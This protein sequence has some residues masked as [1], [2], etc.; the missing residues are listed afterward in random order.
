MDLAVIREELSKYIPSWLVPTWPPSG[1]QLVAGG[2][3][4]AAATAL[5]LKVYLDWLIDDVL[6][7]SR[8]YSFNKHVGGLDNLYDPANQLEKQAIQIPDKTF[9]L[10]EDRKY[11]F[12]ETNSRANQVANAIQK[13]EITREQ[14]VAVL[15]RN[16]PE[17]LF[18]A[19]GCFKMVIPISFLNT[20]LRT[21]ALLHCIR[22]ASTMNLIVDNEPDLLEAVSEIS[23][24]LAEAGVRVFVYGD[25]AEHENLKKTIERCDTRQFFCPARLELTSK[26]VAFYIFTSGT[27]GLPKAAKISYYK[28]VRGSGFFHVFGVKSSDVVYSPLPLYHSAAMI[29]F[30][31]SALLTGCTFSFARK[32]SVRHFWEDC[33]KHGATV[34]QY[35]G[36]TCRYLL[37]RPPSPSDKKHKVRKAIGNG[38][39]RDIWNE[40]KTRYNIRSICE[41]YAAT[42]GNVF[43]GNLRD[44]FGSCG[45]K[46][47]LS[48]K[49]EKVPKSF[50]VK[51][52]TEN[53]QI[54]RDADGM[55]IQVPRG[56][57]GLLVGQIN[58]R[59][60][61]DGYASAEQSNR[62]IVRNVV[63]KGDCYFNTG[64]MLLWDHDY[65]VYF[66]DR[67]GDTFRWKGENVSTL[68]VGNLISE[69]AVIE[70]CSVYGVAVP[71]TDG[72][73]G[74]AAIVLKEGGQITSELLK[75]IYTHCEHYLPSY[76]RPV[77]LRFMSQL[78]I[79]GTFK[80]QKFKLQQEGFDVDVPDV[81]VR[82]GRAET[83]A[84]LTTDVYEGILNGRIKV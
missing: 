21:K 46:S 9:L 79:T 57:P 56:T 33:D 4:L 7:A 17:L 1:R 66:V 18:L 49:S 64:D 31:S 54:V 28:L 24:E 11:T 44:K 26:D 50:F 47:P 39:R 5:Y 67:V 20:N 73:C 38:L 63:E 27:T 23:T 76:A 35:I 58:E 52:D 36:E 37:T 30:H 14:K 25:H 78:H 71:G 68:E 32:F 82:D 16:C 55:C 62:K 42:E 43:F 61:F 34:I 80:H 45:R 2:V 84:P 10:F 69:L 13:L 6:L 40:F 60:R 72:K 48:N 41:F 70:D 65:Y 15:M 51:Y 74:M 12:A 29:I 77:F 75:S 81:Y 8:I 3:T 59:A 22:D 19:H 53:D 83:Y